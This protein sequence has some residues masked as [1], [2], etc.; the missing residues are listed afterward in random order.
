MIRYDPT[1]AEHGHFALP[2]EPALPK[3]ADESN[4]DTAIDD[5]LDAP[6]ITDPV[7]LKS[8][9]ETPAT[10]RFDFATTNVEQQQDLAS[11]HAE[12]ENDDDAEDTKTIPPPPKRSFFFYSGSDARLQ[13]GVDEF[14][15]RNET[16]E[17]RLAESQPRLRAMREELK[18]RT[19]NARNKRNR[20][21]FRRQE[22]KPTWVW[23][24][25]RRKSS[26]KPA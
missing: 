21:L 17:Q 5:K 23:N 4:D 16:A 14:W 26:G 11:D 9:L 22:K 18:R 2:I 25:T 6:F 15:C 1:I 8:A 24:T 20:R 10:F 12:S 7:Q 13:R 19:K 3:S